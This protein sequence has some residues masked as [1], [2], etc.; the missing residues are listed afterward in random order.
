MPEDIDTTEPSDGLGGASNWEA[1]C[2]GKT[3]VCSARFSGEG[4]SDIA[5][6]PKL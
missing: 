3:F 5:C 4:N 1:T 2:H 6:S